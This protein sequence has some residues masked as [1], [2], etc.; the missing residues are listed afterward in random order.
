MEA[1][2]RIHVILGDVRTR[3]R[4]R[5]LAR[6]AGLAAAGLAVAARLG[7]LVASRLPDTW[8]PVAQRALV[9]WAAVLVV[10]VLAG[11]IVPRRRLR[12]DTEVAK[13]VGAAAPRLASDL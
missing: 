6:A 7:P 12:T 5:T 10:V 9:A 13:R 11:L 3:L 4:R 8:T 2:E 1:F